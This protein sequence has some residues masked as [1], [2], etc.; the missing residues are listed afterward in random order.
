MT[1]TPNS[2]AQTTAKK[3]NSNI[4][5]RY[6]VESATTTAT[7]STTIFVGLEHRSTRTTITNS[8]WLLANPQK[9]KDNAQ[10]LQSTNNKKQISKIPAH[11][12]DLNISSTNGA[13]ITL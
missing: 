3:V 11:L 7:I 9:T 5:T 12:M 1:R 10:G 6:S 2:K 13:P 8:W 4:D